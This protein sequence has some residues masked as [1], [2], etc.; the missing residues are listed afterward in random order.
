MEKSK[1]FD[2]LEFTPLHRKIMLWGSG[3]PFLDGF[4]LVIIGIA[5]E[6]LIP[7]L[8][9]DAQM[10]GLV[11]AATLAGLFIGTALFGYVAD[12]IGR[13]LMIMVN[14]VA[15]AVLSAA[16]MF[17]TSPVEL[18]VLRFL[19]GVVIGA[20]YPIAT[21]MVA[22]F[23]ST[24]QRAFTMGFIAAMW[25]VGATAANFVGYMFYDMQDGWRW[26]FGSALIPCVIIFFGRFSLPES[27]RW[28]MKKG[29]YAE[30][31]AIMTKYFGKGVTLEEE[32]ATQTSYR[33]L[34]EP[35]HLKNILFIGTIWSCQ[36]IPMFAIYTFGP[37]IIG[38]FGL[39]DGRDAALGNIVISA[40]FMAGCLPAVFWL[41]SI[42]RR[43]LLIGSFAIMTAALALLGLFEN[44]S[45]WVIVAAF[46]LYA[47]FSGGPGILQWLYPNELFPTE[48]RASAVGAV[49]SVSRIG[50]IISTYALP[51]FM[52]TY[53]I[54]ATMMAGAAISLIGLGISIV[55]APETKGM[56]L[57]ETSQM[58]LKQA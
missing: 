49:M 30:A 39:V 38:L 31:Q 50:T 33:T 9:L 42:G 15:I 36:V 53:G 34:F 11:G 46:G 28:L 10:I 37:Q 12:L 25:Y 27:P 7:T 26:M 58:G 18:I 51:I 29:R 55:M 57:A 19:I 40:F 24:K 22:E 44:P 41:N 52:T 48:I 21:S 4:V 2:D 45:I 32:E 23:S 20:D 6:Q 43:P 1:S 56:S 47:F 8:Q 13:K 3:G 17:V 16:T 14:V 5:L 35:R 54:S